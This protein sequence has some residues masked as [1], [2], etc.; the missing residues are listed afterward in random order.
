MIW[1]A[2][3]TSCTDGICQILACKKGET[4]REDEEHIESFGL[5]WE[6]DRP[7]T[8]AVSLFVYRGEE[9]NP[10]EF[11]DEGG[12]WVVLISHFLL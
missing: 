8:K 6:A 9:E 12:L 11:I 1:I 3:Q 7:V 10:P 4:E 5:T 2:R